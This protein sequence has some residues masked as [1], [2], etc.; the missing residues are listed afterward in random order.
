MR[1]KTG[2]DSFA[3]QFPLAK[4]D[5]PSQSRGMVRFVTCSPTPLEINERRFS[6]AG[7]DAK[8]FFQK[9]SNGLCNCLRRN[10]GGLNFVDG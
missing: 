6:E 5:T 8:S 10:V 7:A 4:I 3:L 1:V 9:E 2:A